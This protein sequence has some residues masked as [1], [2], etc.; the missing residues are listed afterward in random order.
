MMGFLGLLSS[1]AVGGVI[2]ELAERNNG[3]LGAL[4]GILG[5]VGWVIVALLPRDAMGKPVAKQP[6]QRPQRPEALDPVTAWEQRQKIQAGPPEPRKD[7]R[8]RLA[9]ED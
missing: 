3:K 7:W 5:P 1:M 6:R 2:G 8:D 4:L 9:S